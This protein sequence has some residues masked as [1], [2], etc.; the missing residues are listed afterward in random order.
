[1]PLA[2]RLHPY[3]LFVAIAVSV[4][5]CSS[6]IAH[7]SHRYPVAAAASLDLALTVPAAWYWLLVR[8]GLRSRFTL[9]F[10]TFAGLLRAAFL[11]PDVVPGKLWI[12]GALE[13]AVVTVVIAA[14][15]SS[16]CRSGELENADP[17]ERLRGI[18]RKFTPSTVA[19]KVMASEF[20]VFYY[21]FGWRLKPHV[22]PG[23][24]AFPLHERSG[25]HV[26][27]GCMAA[28]SLL[29]IV[30]VHLLVVYKWSVTAAWVATAVSLLG[31][32][33]MTGMGRA[34]RL[35]P[36]LIDRDSVLVRFGLLFRLRISL[37]AIRSIDAAGELPAGSRVIPRGTA[38]AV[39]IQ[40]VEPLE[41]EL[42]LGFTRKIG[43]IG[44]SADD[45]GSFAS[46]LQNLVANRV[47]S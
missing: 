36:T 37:E 13:L 5:I 19:A 6:V 28:L 10:V 2:R 17:V 7:S 30:P 44:L 4:S 35:R 23:T 24:R 3:F 42:L 25:A 8:P 18:F 46:A 32:V 9:V 27:M 29:E 39:C 21:A 16:G 11:F 20:S 12:G 26:L 38:P 43:A 41:A 15:R 31:A 40:F 45:A 1:M 22:P 47:R 34:F 33:W 14:L